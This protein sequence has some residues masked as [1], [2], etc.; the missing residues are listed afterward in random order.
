MSGNHHVRTPRII[1]AL[2]ITFS[3]YDKKNE[4]Q[5]KKYKEEEKKKKKKKK[6]KKDDVTWY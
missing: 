6:K 5:V 2:S 1:F 3:T 4:I